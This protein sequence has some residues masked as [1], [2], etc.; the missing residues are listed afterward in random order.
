MAKNY[1]FLSWRSSPSVNAYLN[2]T[3]EQKESDRVAF[4][5]FMADMQTAIDKLWATAP[6][7]NGMSPFVSTT[8]VK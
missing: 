3:P 6:C 2:K 1:T 7:N 8:P 4:A 5:K